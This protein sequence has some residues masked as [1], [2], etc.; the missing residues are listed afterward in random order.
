MHDNCALIDHGCKW[1]KRK[2]TFAAP[3]DLLPQQS[4]CYVVISCR[5]LVMI[6][7]P[8]AWI[9]NSQGE[10]AEV[11]QPGWHTLSNAHAD[12][13]LHQGA[14]QAPCPAAIRSHVAWVTHISPSQPAGLSLRGMNTWSRQCFVEL[15]GSDAND[16]LS[17]LRTMPNARE[18]HDCGPLHQFSRTFQRSRLGSRTCKCMWWS[19][20]CHAAR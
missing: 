10:I 6:S 13:M 15:F 5:V 19:H 4:I 11:A 12:D 3:V 16:I 14:M 8:D 20:G 17:C 9:K 1:K 18:A 2:E 7:W